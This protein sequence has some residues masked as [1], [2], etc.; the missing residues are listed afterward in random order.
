[1]N[2]YDLRKAIE[3]T[4]F[5]KTSYGAWIQYTKKGKTNSINLDTDTLFKELISI[6]AYEDNCHDRTEFDDSISISQWDALNIAIRHELKKETEKELK[7]SDIF[8]AI[9]QIIKPKQ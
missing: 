6:G 2:I 1:M 9:A 3:V 8:E 7:A 5:T 4:L